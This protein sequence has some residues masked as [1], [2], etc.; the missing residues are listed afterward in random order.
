MVA[1]PSGTRAATS[2]YRRDPRLRRAPRGDFR[3]SGGVQPRAFGSPFEVGIRYQLAAFN[4]HAAA[5]QLTSAANVLPNLHAYLLRP[6]VVYEAFPFFIPRPGIDAGAFPAYVPLP[7]FYIAEEATAGL[8]VVTPFSWFAA[9]AVVGLLASRMRRS[10][11]TDDKHVGWLALTLAACA[12]VAAV[13]ALVLALSSV[14]YQADW[15]SFVLI[16][17]TIGFWSGHRRLASRPVAQRL[18]RHLAFGLALVTMI[19]GPLLAVTS[20]SGHFE[21]HN[22]A[23]LKRLQSWT[24]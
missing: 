2:D 20:T 8:L 14:R 22:P 23:L 17:A 3:T 6:P 21:K 18:W 4:S 7:S 24:R 15:T 13:P 1:T 9:V 10:S 19:L 12:A 5:D 16:L 11:P